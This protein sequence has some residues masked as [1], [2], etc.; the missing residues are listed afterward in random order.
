L[1]HHPDYAAALLAQGRIL[2]ASSRSAEAVPV[3]RRAARLN[4][5][6]EYQWILADALRLQSLGAEADE[7][8]HELRTRGSV[9]DP[10]THAVYL[11][12]RRME[13]PRAIAL[14]EEEL[15][16]RSDVFTL[17]AHAWA[18]AANG[19]MA[20]AQQVI[21]Q[22]LAEGTVDAR[23]FLHAGVIHAAS[24]RR[25]EANRWL[26]KAEQLRAMLLPSEAEEL[27]RQ[28]TENQGD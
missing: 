10:R 26:K 21:A 12:T 1:R 16:V 20:E 22:A 24:G 5:L 2:L 4:P 25:G 23:L 13:L 9:A 18:L 27:D 6:P 17:D 3:L 19:R 8:E 28:L 11:A 14:T 15:R 7:V